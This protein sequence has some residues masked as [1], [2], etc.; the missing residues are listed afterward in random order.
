[1]LIIRAQLLCNYID[2]TDFVVRIGRSLMVGHLEFDRKS[3][4]IVA[5]VKIPGIGG[6]F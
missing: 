1:M 6:V 3:V 4:L 5:E 2:N